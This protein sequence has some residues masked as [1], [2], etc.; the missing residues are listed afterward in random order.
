MFFNM[1]DIV[2]QNEILVIDIENQAITTIS[3]HE[4]DFFKG[5]LSTGITQGKI[6]FPE[7]SSSKPSLD[8]ETIQRCIASGISKFHVSIMGE[9]IMF[10]R[11]VSRII[12]WVDSFGKFNMRLPD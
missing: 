12:N 1:F 4:V 2:Q 10:L 6:D 9:S 3:V 7:A 8:G 11:L 5:N